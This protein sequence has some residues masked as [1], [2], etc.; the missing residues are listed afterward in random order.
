MLLIFI[1]G[2]SE[3]GFGQFY[4][5]VALGTILEVRH[6]PD[7]PKPGPRSGPAR[8]RQ[9]QPETQLGPAR[10]FVIYYIIFFELFLYFQK[11]GFDAKFLMGDSESTKFYSFWKQTFLNL[12]W[13]V[14]IKLWTHNLP[15]TTKNLPS[16]YFP[17]GRNILPRKFTV[18]TCFCIYFFLPRKST[19]DYFFAN[20]FFLARKLYLLWYTLFLY[21][22]NLCKFFSFIQRLVKPTPPKIF[23]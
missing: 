13:T 12:S 1:F 20:S 6:G 10:I 8:I 23:F 14:S 3:G 16:C 11:L 21:L 17:S 5:K 19:V 18:L 4:L 7:P 9:N 2:C 22:T 15:T